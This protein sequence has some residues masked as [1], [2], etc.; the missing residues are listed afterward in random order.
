M[1]CGRRPVPGPETSQAGP[2]RPQKPRGWEYSVAELSEAAGRYSKVLKSDIA[3]EED[4][5]ESTAEQPRLAAETEGYG[6]TH[7]IRSWG[8]RRGD[9]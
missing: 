5:F 2:G 1:P 4:R 6:G 9:A 8:G 3:Y 7:V